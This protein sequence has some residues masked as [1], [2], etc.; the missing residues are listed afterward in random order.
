MGVHRWW[1]F[2]IFS[3]RPSAHASRV[4][5]RWLGRQTT[6]HQ[7]FLVPASSSGG[8][9][10]GHSNNG[11]RWPHA[12]P[13]GD[14]L[15]SQVL[16]ATRVCAACP[17]GYAHWHR[18]TPPSLQA[19]GS[20]TF[21]RI[22]WL[23]HADAVR[24]LLLLGRKEANPGLL[25]RRLSSSRAPSL[26]NRDELSADADGAP[27]KG[28]PAATIQVLVVFPSSCILNTKFLRISPRSLPPLLVRRRLR[29][30]HRRERSRVPSA[31]S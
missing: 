17:R 1:V 19:P 25:S 18:R 15:P 26:S 14:K 16:T 4:S 6:V 10:L 24:L 30:R 8:G 13:Q 23:A 9:A 20:R 7:G 2:V 12:L 31:R 21:Y 29:F 28:R 11:R 3:L 5:L 22:L 27:L